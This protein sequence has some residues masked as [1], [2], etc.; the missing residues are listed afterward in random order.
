MRP[1]LAGNNPAHVADSQRS[2]PKTRCS[3]N[4]RSRRSPKAAV[5]GSV[6]T[7]PALPRLRSEVGPRCW[8]VAG[9]AF[10]GTRAS[11]CAIALTLTT[12]TGAPSFKRSA[13]DCAR[14]SNQS[15]NYQRASERKSTGSAN[16]R[17]AHR[18]SFPVPSIGK[19]LA[20][21]PKMARTD[22]DEQCHR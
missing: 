17:S 6:Q 9:V 1:P 12:Y 15:P 5:S 19:N 8:A 11:Q 21:E 14:R 3:Q 20:V 4:K 7:S 18:Q 10:T 13:R 16:W 2:L 22:M